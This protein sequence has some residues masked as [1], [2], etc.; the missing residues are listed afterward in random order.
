[1]G[2]KVEQRLHLFTC[3]LT[4]GSTSA[5]ATVDSCQVLSR[6]SVIRQSHVFLCRNRV[7]CFTD[8][9]RDGRSYCFN[10]QP[11]RHRM[12]TERNQTERNRGRELQAE[13][14]IEE[15]NSRAVVAAACCH[16]LLIT[17]ESSE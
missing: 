6:L 15:E 2:R 13:E 9:R 8:S 11:L 1:M 3:V 10:T 14:R 5:A 12:L 7:I 17:E 16:L 4:L